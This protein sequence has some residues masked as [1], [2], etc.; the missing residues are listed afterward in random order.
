ALLAG[1]YRR[2]RLP[3]RPIGRFIAP[4]ERRAG[5]GNWKDVAFCRSGARRFE[6]KRRRQQD[7]RGDD[8]QE[9]GPPSEWPTLES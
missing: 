1:R 7:T 3:H 5:T 9:R 2:F 4:P 8:P 6:V